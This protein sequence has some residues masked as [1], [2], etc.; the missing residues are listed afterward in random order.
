VIDLVLHNP[1]S[2]SFL[3]HEM[4]IW[5]RGILYRRISQPCPKLRPLRSEPLVSHRALDLLGWAILGRTSRSRL[6]LVH[7]SLRV[8]DGKPRTR[9][10]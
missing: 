10:R 6:L 2:V 4:L 1:S 3:D 9:F 8:R 7:Q 5:H